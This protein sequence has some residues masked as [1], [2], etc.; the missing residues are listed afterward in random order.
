MFKL[1]FSG[2]VVKMRTAEWVRVERRPEV[3]SCSAFAP[4][5]LKVLRSTRAGLLDPFRESHIRHPSRTGA[6]LL[7]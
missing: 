2:S 1:G 5:A 4:V 3:P 6:R 7:R